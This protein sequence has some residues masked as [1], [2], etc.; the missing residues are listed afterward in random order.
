MRPLVG[1]A[2]QGP[3]IT[4]GGFYVLYDEIAESSTLTAKDEED[5][6]F[7]FV[8]VFFPDPSLH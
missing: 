1:L 2:T 6:R 8:E 3:C 5:D 4:S 7:R